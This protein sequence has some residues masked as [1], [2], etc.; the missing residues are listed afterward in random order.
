MRTINLTLLI[1]LYLF[2]T[3][4][5]NAQT[6]TQKDSAWF[7][8]L[9]IGQS[10]ATSEQQALPAQFNITFPQHAPAT[11]LI[12]LGISADLGFSNPK[13]IAALTA[14]YH[15]NT[16]TDSMQNNLQLGIKLTK[17]FS[18]SADGNTSWFLILDPQYIFD[19]VAKQHSLATDLLAT[20]KHKGEGLH[21]GVRNIPSDGSTQYFLSL[22]GGTQLQQVFPSDT[23]T[24]KGFKIRPL[25]IGTASFSFDRK[26]DVTDPLITI[27]ATYAQR[28]A[29]V[30][31]TNDGEKFSHFLNTGV[32]YVFVSTPVKASI[33]ASYING[34]DYFTG[35]KQQQY[36]L[37]SLNIL[38]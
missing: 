36:F 15:R 24:A 6:T 26:K 25:A 19:D 30:N 10:M 11:Y 16:L 3:S 27:F 7:K 28:V 37:I 20:W 14:E 13:F 1:A 21:F 12:N 29:V 8:N 33:G 32:S 9:K 22:I 31:T 2:I 34:S 18:Y 5:A 23:T 38:K 35:L 17:R 4:N